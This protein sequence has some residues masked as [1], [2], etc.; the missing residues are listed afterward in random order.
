M[1][2][3]PSLFNKEHA[4]IA[5]HS[6]ITHLFSDKHQLGIKTL[7]PEDF[8]YRGYYDNTYGGEDLDMCGGWSYHNVEMKKGV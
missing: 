5:L 3:A 8:H 4:S 7:H 1:A 2:I 6:A